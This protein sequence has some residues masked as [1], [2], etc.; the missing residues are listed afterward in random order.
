M[1]MCPAPCYVLIMSFPVHVYVWQMKVYKGFESC[2][3]DGPAD[4]HLNLWLRFQNLG[5]LSETVNEVWL[6]PSEHVCWF[7]VYG[8]TVDIDVCCSLDAMPGPEWMRF[9]LFLIQNF[10]SM[11]TCYFMHVS[12]IFLCTKPSF[13]FLLSPCIV[14]CVLCIFT[15]KGSVNQ[16]YYY[17][18]YNI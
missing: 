17:Q 4:R 6:L 3:S 2:L 5:V 15:E 14:I 1:S 18:S 12:D 9:V 7:S 11:D 8:V 10:A 13:Q 16:S